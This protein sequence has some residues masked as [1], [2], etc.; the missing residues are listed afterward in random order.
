[1]KKTIIPVAVK[2]L[3]G[4]YF[5]K[6][7]S[8]IDKIISVLEKEGYLYA[9]D[10][11]K[12][13]RLEHHDVKEVE[14]IASLLILPILVQENMIGMLTIYTDKSRKF[15]DDEIE[16]IIALAEQGGMAVQQARLFERIKKNS[17]LFFNLTANLNSSLDIKKILHIMTADISDAFD[18][19]GMI[20]RLLNRETGTLDLVANY[21]VS[22]KFLNKGPV[23][24]EKS[25]TQ[26]MK[27]ETVVIKNVAEDNRI[28]YKNA[29][30]E[31]GIVS[32]LSVPIK[33][34]GEVIG[35]MRIYSD[36]ERDFPEDM[37]LLIEALANQGGLAIQN[38]SMYLSLADAKKSLEDEIWS[39]MMWF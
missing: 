31:E 18:M 4:D 17:E 5:K 15:S 16:F 12:D 39:H 8:N 9:S 20:I 33:V 38:A 25:I 22:E 7:F 23:Y 6:G 37:V 28:Q 19:K 29:M 1:M 10:A 35:A 14:G 36:T 11:T 34:K 32:M 30:K 27:G 13:E 26:V 24:A 3:S 21:G 2:G